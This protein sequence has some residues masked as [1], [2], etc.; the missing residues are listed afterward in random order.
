M[1]RIFGFRVLGSRV[2]GFR[3]FAPGMNRGPLLMNFFRFSGSE[4][5]VTFCP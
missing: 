3:G 4:A 1:F 2:L 5:R